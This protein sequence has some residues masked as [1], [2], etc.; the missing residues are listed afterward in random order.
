[1]IDGSVEEITNALRA[2]VDWGGLAVR[3]TVNSLGNPSNVPT[4][5]SGLIKFSLGPT[6]AFGFARW[7]SI[8]EAR[9]EQIKL[10]QEKQ[11][12][13]EAIKNFLISEISHNT[14]QLAAL[15]IGLKETFQKSMDEGKAWEDLFELWSN[16]ASKVPLRE[17]F[18]SLELDLLCD[19]F[20]YEELISLEHYYS[21]LEQLKG[22]FFRSLDD[23]QKIN[24][25]N[26]QQ[27]EQ[28]IYSIDKM[29]Q[30]V[31]DEGISVK[32]S[33]LNSQTN[34]DS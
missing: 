33:V 8:K 9:R 17:R 13:S 4:F 5:L 26:I 25:C 29:I 16:M 14:V 6:L 10:E 11:K 27:A 34:R 28:V 18:H 7:S 31:V 12:K 15:Q 24:G 19:I 22:T 20:V 32:V 3:E 30:L 23:S 21:C 1:M 2:I